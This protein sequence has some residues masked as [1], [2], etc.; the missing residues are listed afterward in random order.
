VQQICRALEVSRSAY[1][2]WRKRQP[3]STR[4][5]LARARVREAFWRHSRRYGAR[6]IVAE[7]K[8]EGIKIGRHRVRQIMREENLRA[9]QPKSFVPR[10]TDSRHA[11]RISPNLL[12]D[13]APCAA[14]GRVLVGD[15][16]YLPLTNGEWAYLAT[17]MDLF[18]RR[19]L[20]WA[21]SDSIDE[22]LIIAAFEKVVG[23]K[24]L[25]PDAI[26]HSDRGGQYTGRRFRA[27][28][29]KY[30]CRQSMSRAANVYDN[31][32]AESLFSRYKAEL[33]ENGAFTDAAEARMESFNYI[34]GYYNRIRR[35]SSLGYKSP[36]EYESEYYLKESEKLTKKGK[37]TKS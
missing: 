17:W 24:C 10:T 35:H 29:A 36:L 7:L 19:I 1:Y 14:P 32:F 28:L 33:L 21:V 25:S 3:P 20:G 34:E 31:A 22:N 15:I 5:L 8:A 27:L 37:R 18:S 26:V 12:L 6:R 16:T 13:S 11:G 2:E 30:G 23:Q 9:I 4:A